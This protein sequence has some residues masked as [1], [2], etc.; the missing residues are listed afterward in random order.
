MQSGVW[1]DNQ[2]RYDQ[3]VKTH[4]MTLSQRVQAGRVADGR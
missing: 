2:L 1:V 3:L 4:R